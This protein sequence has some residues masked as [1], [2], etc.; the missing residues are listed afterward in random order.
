MSRLPSGNVGHAGSA[1]SAEASATP[2]RASSRVMSW[3]WASRTGLLNFASIEALRATAEAAADGP[4]GGA[5]PGAT[6]GGSRRGGADTAGTN[7]AVGL[8]LEA[9]AATLGADF[10]TGVAVGSGVGGRSGRAP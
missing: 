4:A 6:G 7:T 9:S 10:G 1:R 5:T 8:P 3:R 2:H